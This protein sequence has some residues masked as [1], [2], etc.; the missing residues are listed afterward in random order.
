[1]IKLSPPSSALQRCAGFVPLS[2]SFVGV[3]DGP[4]LKFIFSPLKRP[5]LGT[6]ELTYRLQFY[7]PVKVD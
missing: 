1:M 4:R 7:L 6:A 3:L 5:P 2:F